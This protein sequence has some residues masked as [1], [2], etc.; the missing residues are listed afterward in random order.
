MAGW[1]PEQ[2]WMLWNKD[3][4]L[5]FARNQTRDTLQY[6]DCDNPQLKHSVMAYLTDAVGSSD[7][8]VSTN[9]TTAK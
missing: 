8:V 9:E 7:S 2:V 3:K 1:A 5:D 6:S 4:S